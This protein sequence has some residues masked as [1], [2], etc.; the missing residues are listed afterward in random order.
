M[1]K[2]VRYPS[3]DVTLRKAKRKSDSKKEKLDHVISLV[4]G[5]SEAKLDAV[6]LLLD[7]PADDG[8]V[9]S[10]QDKLEVNERTIRYETGKDKGIPAADLIKELKSRMKKK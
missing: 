9:F 4:S 1:A 3:V 10:E 5:M 2:Q 6:I 8:Y 7:P